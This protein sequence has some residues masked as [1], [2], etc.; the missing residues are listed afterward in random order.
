MCFHDR[1]SRPGQEAPYPQCTAAGS[2]SALYEHS[3]VQIGQKMSLSEHDPI[4]F[5]CLGI[6][7]WNQETWHPGVQQHGS[8]SEM[9]HR[10]IPS[11]ERKVGPPCCFLLQPLCSPHTH[12]LAI[13]DVPQCHPPN[14]CPS[15][16]SRSRAVQQLAI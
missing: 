1:E 7:P 12:A 14:K 15:K 3:M 16:F 5:Y 2:V 9:T 4:R 8:A 11:V 10:E 6:Q 13:R